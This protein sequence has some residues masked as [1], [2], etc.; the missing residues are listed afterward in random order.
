[1]ST[2]GLELTTLGFWGHRLNRLAIHTWHSVNVL[3]LNQVFPLLF[4]Y[5]SEHGMAVGT[6]G[7]G[8]PGPPTFQRC[9]KKKFN[10]KKALEWRK[11]GV[12]FEFFWKK[13]SARFARF[14]IIKQQFQNQY[15]FSK[16][17]LTINL[18]IFRNQK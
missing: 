14:L 15:Y 8:G 17:R 7:Q 1:M 12:K 13:I 4:K 18:F 3:K 9:K 16:K 2:A 11:C 10:G 5:S 6:G